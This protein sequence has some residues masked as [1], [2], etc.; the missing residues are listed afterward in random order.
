MIAEILGNIFMVFLCIMFFLALF[1]LGCMSRDC[2][3]DW[4]KDNDTGYLIYGVASIVM[5]MFLCIGGLTV[6][7]TEMG[8]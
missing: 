4:K 8:W 1:G 2:F 3:R 5:I 7:A 6:L